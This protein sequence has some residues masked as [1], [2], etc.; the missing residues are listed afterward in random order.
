MT[1]RTLLLSYPCG[2]ILTARMCHMN[3]IDIV[4]RS[5]SLPWQDGENIPWHDPAFS[6]RMLREH[7]T[8]EHDLASRRSHTIDAHVQWIHENVLRKRTSRILDLGCGPGLYASRLAAMG[9]SIVGIDYSPAAIAYARSHAENA[10]LDC[11]YVHEDIRI[12]S[13]GRDFDLVMLI[14]G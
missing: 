9:H 14:Y 10:G 5:I 4:D 6:K 2:A 11:R 7:L 8:Q 3:M 12:A 1:S 13:Y